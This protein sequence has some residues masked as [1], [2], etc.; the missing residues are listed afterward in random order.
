MKA[1]NCAQ[2]IHGLK[3]GTLAHET[4][5]GKSRFIKLKQ[6]PD[7]PGVSLQLQPTARHGDMYRYVLDNKTKANDPCSKCQPHIFSWSQVYDNKQYQWKDKDWM[8]GR[9]PNRVSD[10]SG[11]TLTT[12]KGIIKG[13]TPDGKPLL[14][15]SAMVVKEVHIPDN[16]QRRI[17]RHL[18]KKFL[19]SQKKRFIILYC[20]C[21]LKELMILTGDMTELTNTLFLEH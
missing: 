14:K 15:T 3:S 18:K 11:K 1:I 8:E 5:D 16:H 9:N 10:I 2:E 7:K 12:D 6:D 20:S 21:P 19:M 17:L 4:D 13:V